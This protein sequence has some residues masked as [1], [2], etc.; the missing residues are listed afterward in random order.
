MA[1]QAGGGGVVGDLVRCAEGDSFVG[2]GAGDQS[3]DA[4]VGVGIVVGGDQGQ[5]EC[6][7]GDCGEVSGCARDALT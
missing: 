6:A 5:V 3:P 7:V 4:Q 1:H 2:E